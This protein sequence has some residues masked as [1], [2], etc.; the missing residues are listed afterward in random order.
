MAV[1]TH[2]AG[3]INGHL[4]PFDLRHDLND[5]ADLVELCFADTM[6]G[7]G[8]RYLKGMREAARNSSLINWASMLIEQP[9]VPLSGYV[10]EEDSRLVGNLS[11]VPFLL[12]GQRRYLIANV[13]V[14]P[15]Y[16]RRGIARAMTTRAIEYARQ[17]GAPSTWLQVRDDNPAAI[18]LYLSLGFQ[19]RARRTT[20][21]SLALSHELFLQTTTS[22]ACP[23]QAPRISVIP[24]DPAFW[25]QERIWL[26][27][28]Y[29]PEVAWHMPFNLN[30]LRP[31][32]IGSFLRLF[33]GTHARHWLAFQNGRPAAALVWQ[34]LHT[35]SDLL[36]LAASTSVEETSL[37]ELLRSARQELSLRRP[38]TLDYPGGQAVQA[39]RSAGFQ[40]KHTLIWM[41]VP[42]Q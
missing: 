32:L 24:G 20:W 26:E 39:I 30:N 21:C 36:W 15:A 18:S 37:Y 41:E 3:S 14:H 25:P 33:N 28:T 6:D 13:A 17:H 12:Q 22:S 38:L 42:F 23:P 1:L 8:Q 10:W 11:L 19:E 9:P 16:R 7:D 27:N 35:P 4:R 34:T 5:V 2:V 31:G 29:P 40:Q